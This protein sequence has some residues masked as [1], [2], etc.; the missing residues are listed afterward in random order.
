MLLSESFSHLSD[1][2]PAVFDEN[3]LMARL[4]PLYYRAYARPSIFSFA[5]IESPDNPHF[6]YMPF[7]MQSLGFL[8]SGLIN[9]MVNG[10][11]SPSN[12]RS[13]LLSI[14]ISPSS[15]FFFRFDV[16][17]YTEMPLGTIGRD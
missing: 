8:I 2:F 11:A 6:S 4:S 14:K 13:P 3:M 9:I 16:D 17:Y 5:A 1:P 12:T 7:L 15:S 10:D